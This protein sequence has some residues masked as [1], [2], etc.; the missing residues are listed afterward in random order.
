MAKHQ[1]DLT[2]NEVLL[3]DVLA[4]NS[5]PRSKGVDRS[6][7]RFVNNAQ[8]EDDEDDEPQPQPQLQQRQPQ[9][10]QV[11]AH[12]QSSAVGQR[13]SFG[14]R[15]DILRV[16]V[17]PNALI[18]AD[19]ENEEKDVEDDDAEEEEDE[20]EEDEE[21]NGNGIDCEEEEDDD[22][23]ESWESKFGQLGLRGSPKHDLEHKNSQV[24]RQP[25]EAPNTGLNINDIF[26]LKTNQLT[27]F[28]LI[29]FFFF[30]F[31]HGQD[32]LSPT[33]TNHPE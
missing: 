25:G 19:P 28:L 9:L 15:R 6:K 2:E 21:Y 23:E 4:N 24:A 29:F 16:E 13:P 3:A 10:Q 12:E 17:E 30:F 20:A 32:L 11:R 27:T 8:D 26:P 33:I 5:S 22:E 7:Y 18:E 31:P 14:Q 1:D